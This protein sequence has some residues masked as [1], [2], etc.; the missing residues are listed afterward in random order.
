MS[1]WRLQVPRAP[2]TNTL[3]SCIF[4]YCLCFC[5]LQRK[6][7]RVMP[8]IAGG[9]QKWSVEDIEVLHSKDT[10]SVSSRAGILWGN[11]LYYIVTFQEKPRFRKNERYF[12]RHLVGFD[13]ATVPDSRFLGKWTEIHVESGSFPSMCMLKN[14]H[15]VRQTFSTNS[16][17]PGTKGSR[18]Y[19]LMS[20]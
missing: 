11:G 16:W 5:C 4:V 6:V 2:T 17:T 13:S 8:S 18:G 7:S 15:Y 10:S 1:S 20:L 9:I 19:C 3:D 12:W 14:A